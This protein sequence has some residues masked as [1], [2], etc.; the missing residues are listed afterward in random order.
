[1]L[2]SKIGNMVARLLRAAVGRIASDL[3]LVSTIQAASSS[4]ALIDLLMSDAKAFTS[5]EDVMG[6]AFKA[7]SGTGFIC[8][9]GVY[10]GQSLNEIARHYSSENVYG[11]DTFSGLPEFWRNGFPKGAFDVSFENLHFEK[12][13]LLYKG[14]FDQSLPEF[15]KQ[16]ESH[17]KL[18]HV[19]CDLYSSSIS[20]LRLLSPRIRTGTVIVFDEY[21]NYPGWQ[22][23]EHRAFRE[24]LDMTG[25]GCRYIAYNKIGQQV[26]VVITGNS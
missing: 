26:A 15:L 7:A 14:L 12:N 9:L 21:F 24:F 11:F 2:K 13:C 25:F 5:R 10:R 22:A 3:E 6:A 16:V 19:D 20:A 1:M 23:H 4:A 18:I 17:A 8:E